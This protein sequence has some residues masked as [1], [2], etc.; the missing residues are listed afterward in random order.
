MLIFRPL[1]VTVVSC[2]GGIPHP[3]REGGADKFTP[4]SANDAQKI[5]RPDPREAGAQLRPGLWHTID[6]RYP[7]SMTARVLAGFPPLP[8]QFRLV[9]P[10]RN[11][12]KFGKAVI[13][14]KPTIWNL[15]RVG[16]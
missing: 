10:H 15:W 1:Y 12:Y 9:L 2:P 14:V 3:G 4:T 8:W 16:K 5:M 7:A 6:E 11:V 13:R